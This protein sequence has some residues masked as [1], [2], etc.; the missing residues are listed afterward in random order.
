MTP[1]RLKQV[2]NA[3]KTDF[4]YYAKTILQQMQYPNQIVFYTWGAK[5]F[6]LAATEEK[7]EPV[8]FFQV[9]GRKFKGVVM[10]IYDWAD[11]YRIEFVKNG[12]VTHKVDE[13]YFDELQNTI[14]EYIEKI[15]QYKF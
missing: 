8:L 13:V 1:T 14:D 12:E 7:N 6:T 11:Y 10:I 5:G 4:N 15:K 9:S 3:D 2:A